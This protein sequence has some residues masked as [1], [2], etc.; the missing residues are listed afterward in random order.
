MANVSIRQ[1]RK[2]DIDDVLAI[3]KDCH[4]NPWSADLFLHELENPVSTIDL[5]WADDKVAGFLCS[6]LIA[7]ELEILNV[8]TAPDFRR[9][10]IAAALMKHVFARARSQG[11]ERAFL[12]VRVGNLG[13]I[14]LYRQFGFREVAR[15]S[16]YYTDGED[17][18][19]MQWPG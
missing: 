19:L 14:K 3:E 4:E 10:G 15:R 11:L 13:A 2:Q 18:L 9:R 16:R 5:F 1:M 17:A 6:W 12:E 8:A 7:G